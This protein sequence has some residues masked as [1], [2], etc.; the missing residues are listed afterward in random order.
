MNIK[1]SACTG[2]DEEPYEQKVLGQYKK[3]GF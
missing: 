2:V 3:T 1:N